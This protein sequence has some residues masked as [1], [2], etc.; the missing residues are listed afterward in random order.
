MLSGDNIAGWAKIR[1]RTLERDDNRCRICGADNVE[2]KLNVHH[3]DYVHA[4]NNDRN[5]VTLCSVCHHAIHAEGYQPDL[6]EDWPVPWG[7]QPNG[8]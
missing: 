4:H 2:A 3:I 7:L 6:Y 1:A 8:N 5:L